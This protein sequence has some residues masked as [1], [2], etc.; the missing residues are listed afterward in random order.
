MAEIPKAYSEQINFVSNTEQIQNMQKKYWKDIEDFLK[1][2]RSSPESNSFI[3]DIITIARDEKDI[4]DLAYYIMYLKSIK[5]HIFDNKVQLSKL[6][7]ELEKNI[8]DPVVEVFMWEYEVSSIDFDWLKIK[9]IDKEKRKTYETEI[10]EMKE[11]WWYRLT[12]KKWSIE[13]VLYIKY[14]WR[15]KIEF[16]DEYNKDSF[17]WVGNIQQKKVKIE[18]GKYHKNWSYVEKRTTENVFV[19]FRLKGKKLNFVFKFYDYDKKTD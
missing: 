2:D 9:W 4:E 15:D 3:Q 17:I 13:N 18:R 7:E 11:Y 10:K 8:E 12:Y 1:T 19:K 16:Y 6:K 5:D 14:E